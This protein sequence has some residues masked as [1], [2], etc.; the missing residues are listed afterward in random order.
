MDLLGSEKMKGLGR[1][2]INIYLNTVEMIAYKY[3][4]VL[5]DLLMDKR[6]VVVGLEIV[7]VCVPMQGHLQI[8]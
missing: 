8:G 3:E 7:H 1:K 6:E 2:I 5:G 4:D